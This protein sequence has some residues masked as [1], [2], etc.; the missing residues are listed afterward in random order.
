MNRPV[1]STIDV[2]CVPC[3]CPYVLLVSARFKGRPVA[4]SVARLLSRGWLPGL[5]DL[6]SSQE[7]GA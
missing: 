6:L 3:G 1:L 4:R 2:A 5:L 7:L